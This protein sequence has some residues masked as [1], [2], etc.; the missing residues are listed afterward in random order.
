MA[1]ITLRVKW[2][3]APTINL[4]ALTEK[5]EQKSVSLIKVVNLWGFAAR[6]R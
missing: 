3:S 2:L 4:Q 1:K 6:N 5:N